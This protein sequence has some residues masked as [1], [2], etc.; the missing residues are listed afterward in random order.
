M[1]LGRPH[2]PDKP[3]LAHLRN[4]SSIASRYASTAAAAMSQR[5]SASMMAATLPHRGTTYLRWV[6]GIDG[7]GHSC[8]SCPDVK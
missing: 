1:P 3:H 8:F 2:S 7:L 4:R 6:G 5:V